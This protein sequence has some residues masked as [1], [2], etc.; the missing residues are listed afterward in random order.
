MILFIDVSITTWNMSQMLRLDNAYFCSYSK[1]LTCWVLLKKRKTMST[2]L[3]LRWCTW[4]AWSSSRE[5]EKNRLR[6]MVRRWVSKHN[7][8]NYP[9]TCRS[10]A[11]TLGFKCSHVVMRIVTSCP[12]AS[13]AVGC[14]DGGADVDPQVFSGDSLNLTLCMFFISDIMM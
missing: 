2:R 9:P 12:W 13:G 5:V 10:P 11:R 4:V 3:R 8:P 1:P 14:I 6:Q 7:L